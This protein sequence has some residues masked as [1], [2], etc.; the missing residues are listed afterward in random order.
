MC[1]WPRVLC[2]GYYLVN[3]ISVWGDK[4]GIS[5][6]KYTRFN[7]DR[8]V[9]YWVTTLTYK[10]GHSKEQE[11]PVGI[12]EA[13]CLPLRHCDALM[14]EMLP[15]IPLNFKNA[16]AVVLKSEEGK[17]LF[18]V[19]NYLIRKEYRYLLIFQPT[20]TSWI[21]SIFHFTIILLVLFLQKKWYRTQN[22]CGKS[23][24]WLLKKFQSRS[25][26]SSWIGTRPA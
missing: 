1:H 11:F 25:P 26:E 23:Q 18:H 22:K 3:N 5:S 2:I 16:V 12:R 24:K 15:L 13:P 7:T 4:L 19:D 21:M 9:R 8:L 10:L 20:I 14:W 17:N 6:P